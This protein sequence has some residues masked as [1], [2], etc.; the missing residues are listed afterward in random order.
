VTSNATSANTGSTI[1]A[2]D[3]SGNFSAGTITATLTGTASNAAL[4][5]SIDSA[6]FLRSDA[7]DTYTSGTLTFGSGTG[8][9]LSTNDIYANMRVI[10]NASGG[11]DDGMYIGYANANSGVTRIYGGGSTATHLAVNSSSV[12]FDGNTIW[13]AGNDGSGSGLDADLLDGVSSA[14]FLRSDANDTASGSYS[15]TNSYNEFG[16]ATGSVSND[17]S[18]N[19]R[20]NIAGSSHARLDVKSVSD[21]IIT[22]MYSHTGN[23]SGKVGTMSNHPLTLMAN[24]IEAMR[25]DASGHVGIGTTGIGTRANS[26]SI[27][28]TGSNSP[29]VAKS[30]SYATVASILPWSGCH[31]YIGTGIYYDDGAWVHA[32]DNTTNS[33]FALHG[34]GANWYSSNNST[35]SWNVAS[36]VPLWNASGQWN[37][38]INT[39]YDINTGVITGTATSARYADLAERYT[40][41]AD[42]EAGTVVVFGGDEEVTQSTQRLDRRVAGIVSTDPA[43]LMNSELENSV[44][45][46]LQGRVPCKV[47]GEI[48]KGDMMVTSSTPGHAEAWREESNPPMGGVIGKAL[49]NKTGAGADVIEVVVGRL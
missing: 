31:N 37:G 7:S 24:G 38:D 1:V 6:S 3:A 39:T 32:S 2:R 4:L 34:A 18:W 29:W 28:S 23:G 46:G 27:Q 17:G 20:V 47:V 11:T 21:G 49:E 5:D 30:S 9:D 36:G 14:S 41:D 42:Y 8:L 35:G 48:R 44:A 26:L 15:F 10:Q 33:L 13:H 43:Y 40:T 22:T 16:N 25:L 19:A 12:T 45:V